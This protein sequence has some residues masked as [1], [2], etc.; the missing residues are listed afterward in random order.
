MIDSYYNVESDWQEFVDVSYIRQGQDV[1][2]ALND[3]KLRKLGW[4]PKREFDQEIEHIVSSIKR[5]FRW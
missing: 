4:S 2:Y 3:E 1:R 5:N